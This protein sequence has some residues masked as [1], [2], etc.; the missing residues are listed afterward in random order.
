[1]ESLPI[2]ILL[3]I[4][5]GILTGIIPALVAGVLGFIFKYFTGVSIPGLGVVVLALAVAG[6]NG[7]LLALN[8]PTIRASDNGTA[9]LVAII[10]VLMLALYAHAKGDKL[11][12]SLPRR[13][14][15]RKLTQRSLSADVIELVGNRGQ[16]RIRPAGE[17]GNMEGYPP[18][19]ADLRGE[20]AEEVW[21]FPADVPL[22]E[23]ETRLADRLR[24]DYDLADVAVRLDERAR[25]TIN[26]APP[27][28]S[29]SKRVPE[30]E[31]AVS[32][33]ALL[34]TGIARGD[35]VRI[36]TGEGTVDSTVLSARTSGGKD[37]KP[38]PAP[39]V[40]DVATGGGG[41]VA[42]DGGEDVSVEAAPTSAPFTDGG[43]GRLT[44]SVSRPDASTLLA[45]ERG[46]TVVLSR[47]TRR[48][49]ELTSLL[50]R[51]GQQFRRVTVRQ[52]GPLDGVPIAEVNPRERYGVAVLAVRGDS[53]LIAPPA[54]TV[55]RAGQ[56]LFVVGK[57]D[58]LTAF[59][60]AGE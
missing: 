35:K 32:I 53:W 21:T 8:D 34:P 25:A 9:L 16:V 41:D 19:P 12:G 7:G 56:E 50:R 60:E 27:T 22:S 4:Y 29:L 14:S 54:D 24:T 37:D 18:L 59:K 48:E 58:A 49:F 40:E 3:G 46:R 52:D 1:M 26:A 28:G 42:T 15:L 57:R 11:G 20:I 10:V 30:G 23:L 47:G 51:A 6:V 44:V 39:V 5:L 45:A 36:R 55:L 43:E 33:A 31:R 2:Q 38:Q 13:V 17:I